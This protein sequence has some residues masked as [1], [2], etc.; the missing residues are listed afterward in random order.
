MD[1]KVSLCSETDQLSRI[2]VGVNMEK[3]R[4]T[5]GDNVICQAMF[6]AL[7]PHLFGDQRRSEE[8]MI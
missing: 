4:P 5:A 6:K 8:K 1:D 2:R 7:Y 3:E